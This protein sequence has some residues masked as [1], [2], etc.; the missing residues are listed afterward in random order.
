MSHPQQ[1]TQTVQGTDIVQ[2]MLGDI[3]GLM[4]V[5]QVKK[6]DGSIVPFDIYLLRASMGEA[7]KACGIHEPSVLARFLEQSVGKLDRE[8]DGHT[9]PS[10]HEITQIVVTV[11]IDNNLPFVAKK[12]LQQQVPADR[13]I[14]VHKKGPGIR[15]E[16]Y[17]TVDGVHP[18]DALEWDLRDAVITNE[19]GKVVFE[20]KGVELPKS[21]S[22]TATNI[23][24]SKYFRGKIGTPERE[25]SVKQMVG[26]VATTIAEWGARGQYFATPKDGE[27]FE[28]ELA[29]ILVNQMAAFNSPVWF[30]VGVAERP[31]CSACFIQSVRDDMRSI[32]SLARSEF[33]AL[34]N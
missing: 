9:V 20:Q 28:A 30:N 4:K 17:F 10:T 32:M 26:R 7:L 19:K 14:T 6:T 21:W 31:Q 8:F 3:P 24:V 15:F 29:H 1:R 12:F 33:H 22:Q 16:R 18:F 2:S 34:P 27:V 13:K 25:W 23:V 11:A 5:K